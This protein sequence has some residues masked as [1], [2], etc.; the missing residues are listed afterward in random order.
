[1]IDWTYLT[2]AFAAQFVLLAGYYLLLDRLPVGQVKRG[3]LLITLLASFVIPVLPVYPAAA[4]EPL[5]TATPLIVEPLTG[6]GA[7]QVPVSDLPAGTNSYWFPALLWTVYFTGVLFS[8]L[9]L[10]AFLRGVASRLKRGTRHRRDRFTEVILDDTTPPH[11][12]LR[13]VFHGRQAAAHSAVL[14]HEAAHARQLHSVDRLLVAGL[15][16]IWWWNPL[17]LVYG[18][19]VAANHELLADRAVLD[20]GYPAAAYQQTLLDTLRPASAA[21]YLASPAGFSITKKRFAMM[22][23]VTPSPASRFARYTLVAGIGIATALFL[24]D[25]A[26]AA[27]PPAEP[28]API[29][30][31]APPRVVAAAVV[32]ADTIPPPPPIPDFWEKIKPAQPNPPSAA[33]LQAW[34]DPTTYGVWIDGQR[35]ANDELQ[36]YS[37]GDFA[38]YYQSRLEKNAT[39]YGKHVFQIDVSTVDYFKKHNKIFPDGTF[40]IRG[41]PAAPGTDPGTGL[42][43]PDFEK[44]LLRLAGARL[45]A[46]PGEGC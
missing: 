42:N 16:I 9:R 35:V 5:L 24:G 23:S 44:R 37:P 7:P 3:Y 14:I 6:E 45:P 25:R 34:K 26:V 33:T 12:F 11:T 27:A 1:M 39:N 10:L 43:V 46:A 32:P 8:T 15:R 41:R 2:H 21:S 19:A 20:R 4:T 36:N 30:S 28:A 18:R 13:W 40:E 38:H 29:A 17:L 22:K 31:A